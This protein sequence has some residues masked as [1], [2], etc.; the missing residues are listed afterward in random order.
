MGGKMKSSGLFIAVTSIVLVCA[1]YNV[2]GPEGSRMSSL[3]PAPS[4]D[5][6]FLYLEYSAAS[7]VLPVVGAAAD[8]L[9]ERDVPTDWFSLLTPILGE[10][11]ETAA[12]LTYS[13]YGVHLYLAARLTRTS[14]GSSSAIGLQELADSR[15][16]DSSVL[17][18]T[19]D[20]GVF[21]LT[22]EN[23][24][25]GLYLRAERGVAIVSSTSDG[26]SRMALALKNKLEPVDP[27]PSRGRTWPGRMLLSDGGLVSGL[28]S[29]EGLP[30]EK[31]RVTVS[32][33]WRE[34]AG[35][36]EMR[37]TIEGLPEVFRGQF[38][39]LLDE[40]RGANY[41]F[42][43]PLVAAAGFIL[44]ETLFKIWKTANAALFL[45]EHLGDSFN[46]L[47]GLLPGRC[48][49]SLCGTG[50]FLLF[51][52][53]GILLELPGRG[54]KGMEFADLFWTGY[55]C[56]QV[57]T[58]ENAPDYPSGGVSSI[59]FSILAAANPRVLKLGM[60]EGD[61]IRPGR[62]RP[63]A[64]YASELEDVRGAFFWAYLDVEQVLSAMRGLE[65]TIKEAGKVVP[66]LE[67]S[68]I[69]RVSRLLGSLGA[70]TL[71]MPTPAGG[72]LEWVYAKPARH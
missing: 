13:K 57:P 21:V 54:V 49:L 65:R 43:E 2:L 59:P 55:R 36:G 22:T 67:S 63:L 45:Q 41:E 10:A 34:R 29:I 61:A 25:E 14:V 53:P 60:I 27:P 20:D 38:D 37:W 5:A 31:E 50:K 19:E 7:A 17:V 39:G 32:A 35:G 28:T 71:V 9:A 30:V 16:G 70:L 6:P 51:T 3:I 66:S 18:R 62:T 33:A 46:F 15:R 42:P 48:V 58:V 47:E 23:G 1:V 40:D 52:I 56:S 12:L 4:E 72:R 8:V 69:A 24:E 64:D 44:P 68:V 26:L 11:G